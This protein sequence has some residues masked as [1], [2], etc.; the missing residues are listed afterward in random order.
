[1]K[2]SL[3]LKMVGILLAIVSIKGTIFVLTDNE[4]NYAGIPMPFVYIMLCTFILMTLYVL[5]SG[6]IK[7]QK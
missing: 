5:W 3:F 6:F 4:F 2:R 7:R 1:M